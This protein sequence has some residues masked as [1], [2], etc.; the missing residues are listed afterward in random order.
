MLSF[1][2]RQISQAGIVSARYLTESCCAESRA[3]P[4]RGGRT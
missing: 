1:H 4:A 3:R 2:L